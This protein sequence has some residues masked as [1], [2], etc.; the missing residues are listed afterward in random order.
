MDVLDFVT[1]DLNPP[2]KDAVE[3]LEGPLLI[4]AGAGSGKTRVLT[5]RMANI[6]GQGVA[7]PDEILCVTFTNKAAKEMEHRI[8]KILSDMGAHVR[9]QL[10]INTFH[11]FCV[12]VLRQ[13]I[14]LLDYKPF[15]GI[16]DSSDQ[17]SQIKKVMT[18]LNINDKMYPAKNFQSRI[19]SAKM[20]GLSPE[21]FEKNA[22]RLMDAKTVEVYKAYEVEMKK[23]NSLDF[24][25]LLMKTY[26]LFRMYPDVLKMYQEKFRYIMVDE[27]Q[28][29]NH[30]Q[31]LL[32]QMLAKAHRNLCVVG[33]ED[34]SIYSWRGAD[35]KNILDFEKD[36]REAKVVKLEEN[37]RSSAN[38]VNAATAVIKNNSQRK[39]KTLFT[40]NNPGDLIHV[41]EEKNEYDEAKFVAKTIQTMMNEG[42]GSY[43]DYAVFYRTNAQS[44]VLEEQLRTLAIPYRLV[45]GV[46]FYERMEIKD[47]LSYMKLAINPADDIALKRIINVPARG[48]GKTTI[49]KIEEFAAQKN[50]NMYQAA[51]KACDERLFNAGTTGKIRRFLEL[52]DEL[53]TNALNFKIVDFYHIV[54]DRTEYLLNLKKDESPEAQAR[55]E[56]LEELDNAIAQFAKERGE[57]STLTSFLEEMAL[58]SDVD[59]LDQEQNSVTLMTL[60]ISKGLEYPYV[61]VVGMEENLFPSGRSLDSDGEE[62]VEEERRLAYVGMTRARQKLWLTY[63]KMRRVWGQ[64][65]MNP[66]SRFIKEIPKEFIDFKAAAEGPRFVSRYGSSS[67]DADSAF[68]S[69][70]W[71]SL[72]SDRN[73]ARPSGF[74]DGQAFP[75][76]E[77]EGAPHGGQFTKGMRVRHP[78]FGAGTVYATEGTGENFKVSVMFTDNTVKKFVVKYARLERI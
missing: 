77:N 20:M 71:G 15:F 16:Y 57:E 55:I 33:D 17:L 23:A 31:Y 32:V 63:A 41:R 74:D 43:N 29:T 36:F 65:Q 72:A 40:S 42:E 30:I 12:R 14:T 48:I 26:E 34:Q 61:F 27:Y 21:A 44:R 54:L 11:S 52:M 7:A 49:E 6:I 59:S 47:I 3:T 18:A 69:P 46:R 60:H 78:T 75:D 28:D 38:I 50:L 9:S 51:G 25:D 39:D 35:I 13:H 1:K 67:Y 62:D 19:S 45:G 73:K 37:Y 10:W 4:L 5:H 76:Y 66:P 24:D 22:K 2:Q 68:D 8:Y 70:R 58:V 56:N 64:E 53:Q